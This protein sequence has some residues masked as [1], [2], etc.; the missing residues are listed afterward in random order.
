MCIRDSLVGVSIF[1]YEAWEKQV[2]GHARTFTEAL[3]ER[4]KNVEGFG[5]PIVVAELGYTGSEE[6]VSSW[7]SE[8]RAARPDMPQLVGAVY[9]DQQE[10]YPWPN[11]FP[12]PDWRLAER[13]TP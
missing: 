7:E 8:V 12:R 6:Y 1:G 10:V 3:T 13:V 5:K 9:F 11:D 4:Y 2:L